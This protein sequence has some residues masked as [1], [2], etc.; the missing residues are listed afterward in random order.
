M[1]LV[2]Q[3]YNHTKASGQGSGLDAVVE[4]MGQRFAR[5]SRKSKSQAA[6]L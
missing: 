2:G 3:M 1:I 5:K 4:E 6:A